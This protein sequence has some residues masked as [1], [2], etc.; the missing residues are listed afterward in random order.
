MG[1]LEEK[2]HRSVVDSIRDVIRDLSG[3]RQMEEKLR[4]SEERYRSII[5]N[6][7]DAYFEVD[8]RGRFTFANDALCKN[9]GYCHDELIGMGHRHYAGKKTIRELYMLFNRVYRTGVPVKSY[10]FELYRKDGSKGYC[11]ISV[12]PIRDEKGD[13]AGFR[14]I[15]RDVTKRK[16]REK[17][18]RH[19]ATHDILTGLPN[20]TLF[21]EMLEQNLKYARR[22]R[23]QL[24]LLFMDLD[25]FK[26][27]NDTFGHETGDQVLIVSAMRLRQA[28][29]E[30]DFIARLG[31]DEFV[32]LV[33]DVSGK[34]GLI[35][36]I[37]TIFTAV[38]KPILIRGREHRL[39]ASI[40]I[41]IYPQD[42]E[43]ESNLM[44]TADLAMYSAKEKG[45]NNYQFYT[46]GIKPLFRERDIFEAHLPQALA[47]NEL[48]LEYQP[49]FDLKSGA[50]RGVEALLRWRNPSLG[51]VPPRKLI[52]V[53][54][55]TGAIIP[56]G[57]WVLRTA[58]LQGA[59]W[60]RQGLPEIKIA[61]NLSHRQLLD[62][63]L[64][65][66]LEIALAE[67]GLKPELLELEITENL[68]LTY[69]PHI[70]SV[71]KRLKGVGVKLALD[72]FGAGYSSLAQIRRLPMDTL[73]I[74]RSIVEKIPGSR[75]DRAMVEAIAGIGRALDLAVVAEGVETAAQLSFL[76]DTSCDLLQGFY[77]SGPLPPREA[78]ALIGK[79]SPPPV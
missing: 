49:E 11:E 72:D 52:S 76:R 35:T 57:R 34:K 73:K 17:Q 45:S 46:M 61:V 39:T 18:I 9:L 59:A 64:T 15:A 47:R 78:A 26:M 16:K 23:Q 3:R 13:I 65:D 12:T 53:A 56:I 1:S 54:E 6:M 7:E 41:S 28:L 33:K 69:F 66:D 2:E 62:E 43:D 32:V 50:V 37:N 21:Q 68:L 74:D 31:G 71:F 67:S 44:K 5:E 42:G 63:R 75:V 48:Y 77:F 60:Q 25:G 10:S 27:I 30:S 36:L 22:Y 29:R 51:Q 79:Q 8:L 38:N 4:R 58:C 19:L 14:G 70:M 20:R 40:G 55:S 24:A